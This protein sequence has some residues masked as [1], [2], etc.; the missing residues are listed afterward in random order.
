[1]KAT[2]QLAPPRSADE[3]LA[4]LEA[5]FTGH[6][7]DELMTRLKQV[8]SDYLTQPVADD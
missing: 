2:G 1:M 5:R 4:R 8:V 7:T 3:A 6:E